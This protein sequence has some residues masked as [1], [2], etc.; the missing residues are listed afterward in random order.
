MPIY[1]LQA[2]A[3]AVE[4]TTC[5]DD[6]EPQGRSEFGVAT[7]LLSEAYVPSKVL[8]LQISVVFRSKEGH[9]SSRED[10]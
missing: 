5:L 1:S 10:Q 7:T 6:K 4:F 3:W 9:G 2:R 8:Y